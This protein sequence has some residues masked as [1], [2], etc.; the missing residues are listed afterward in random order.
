MRKVGIF[1][2]AMLIAV[3]FLP[4][5]SAFIHSVDFKELGSEGNFYGV[6]IDDRHWYTL[7]TPVFDS[8][9]PHNR[10]LNGNYLGEDFDQDGKD[11]YDDFDDRDY[12]E[13]YS[14]TEGYTPDGSGV[15]GGLVVQI[16]S[17]SKYQGLDHPNIRNS[18]YFHIETMFGDN[19]H[20]GDNPDDHYN[21]WLGSSDHNAPAVEIHIKKL[22]INGDSSYTTNKYSFVEFPTDSSMISTYGNNLTYDGYKTDHNPTENWAVD[23]VKDGAS[24]VLSKNPYVG[25]ALTVGNIIYN[26]YEYFNPQPSFYQNS[27]T[28]GNEEAWFKWN[29]DGYPLFA[30]SINNVVWGINDNIND[31]YPESMGLEIYATFHYVVHIPFHTWNGGVEWVYV[32]REITT[33]P[34]YVYMITPGPNYNNWHLGNIAMPLKPILDVSS[35]YTGD[36]IHATVKTID[37]EVG[38]NIYNGAYGNNILKYEV[39]WGDG[40]YDTVTEVSGKPITLSHSYSSANT[41]YVKVR[42]MQNSNIYIKSPWSSA[43]EIIVYSSPSNSPGNPPGSGACPFLYTYNKYNKTWREENNVLVW[44]ENATRTTL[45]TEDSYLIRNVSVRNGTIKMGIGENG[46]D[47]DFIDSVKVYKVNAHGGYEVVEDY[48]G[49]VYTY[50]NVNIPITAKDNNGK[51]VRGEIETEDGY[52]WIGNK[53]N[54]IDAI[55]NLSKRNLL[56]IRGIDNPPANVS[57]NF[58]PPATLSTIW[59]YKNVSGDWIKLKEIKVRHNLHTSAINLN[60]LLHNHRGKIELRFEMRDRNGIDF[61]GITHNFRKV[62]LKRVKLLSSSLGFNELKRKDGKYLRIN[63]GDFVSMEFKGRGNGTYLVKVYGFY[64]N[65]EKIGKG[66]GIVRENK[67]NIAEAELIY[68]LTDGNYVLLPLLEN[69][70]DILWVDWYVDGYYVS[71]EKPLIHL[72]NDQHT[73]ELY[74]FRENGCEEYYS[75]HIP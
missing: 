45:E 55:F 25:T 5:S 50:R 57:T 29:P 47:I 68:N 70:S 12:Y 27:E 11:G 72:I 48:N 24:L 23:M 49:K 40:N 46:N 59:I 51:D 75:L 8:H 7:M 31:G 52:Y 58:R 73:F 54:Y 67:T 53:G 13:L 16:G 56:L 33:P 1:L 61:I 66:I 71:G 39:N 3:M 2:G 60:K 64:F 22:R 26:T 35:T 10:Y 18:L 44:A 6:K 41:Y 34:V 69:Y 17:Y 30:T 4:A 19:Y 74:V 42:A 32:N 36:T 20:E 38:S 65:K 21:N 28:N 14:T 63:P 9:A 15:T 43:A 62:G 37:W